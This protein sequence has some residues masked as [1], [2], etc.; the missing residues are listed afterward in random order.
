MLDWRIAAGAALAA[1]LGV[2]IATSADARGWFRHRG[3]DPEAMLE[4][5]QYAVG[6]FMSKV[7]ATDEQKAEARVLVEDTL[8]VLGA[9]GLDRQSMRTQVVGLL[10]AET[11]DREAVEDLRVEKLAEADQAS[12]ILTDAIVELAEI[13]TPEQRAQLPG[14]AESHRHGWH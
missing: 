13:L 10:S 11:I 6:R 1:I 7:D 5:S 14:M 9:L 3:H 12:R 8:I 2:L 4:H